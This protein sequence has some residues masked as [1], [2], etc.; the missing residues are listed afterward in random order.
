MVENA[1]MVNKKINTQKFQKCDN[2]RISVT[3]E[4]VKV[5]KEDKILSY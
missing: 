4:V 3:I 2:T 5:N 1:E